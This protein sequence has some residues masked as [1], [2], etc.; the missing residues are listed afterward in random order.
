MKTIELISTDKCFSCRACEQIC[1][2]K[3]ITM[4][5]NIEGFFYPEIKEE[6]INCGICLLHCTAN[7]ETSVNVF[8]KKIY[9][10]NTIIDSEY[11]A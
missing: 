6:C 11:I 3:C 8:E 2:K 9:A 5:E 4:T 10:L 1:P 7:V